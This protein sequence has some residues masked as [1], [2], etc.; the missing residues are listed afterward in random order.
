MQFDSQG[1]TTSLPQRLMDG[2]RGME[3]EYRK[4]EAL[5]CAMKWNRKQNMQNIATE[6]LV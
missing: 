6:S 1:L 2:T 5:N 4:D 3:G